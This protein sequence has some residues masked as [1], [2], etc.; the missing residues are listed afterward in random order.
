MCPNRHD[1]L[2]KRNCLLEHPVTEER[3]EPAFGD[4]LDAPTKEFFEF[5]DKAARKPWAWLRPDIDQKIN[6][7][8]RPRITSRH[9]T[10][11]TNPRH[12]VPAR[13]VENLLTL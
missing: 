1:R 5:S 9:G 11:H 4:D 10:K 3:V 13:Q 8:L 6:I 2:S 12:A 7:T